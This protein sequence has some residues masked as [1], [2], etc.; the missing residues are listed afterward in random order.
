[1]HRDI[2]PGNVMLQ[3]LPTASEVTCLSKQYITKVVDLEYAKAY[4]RARQD[5]PITVRFIQL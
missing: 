3:A 4:S 1:M 2:I 5:D